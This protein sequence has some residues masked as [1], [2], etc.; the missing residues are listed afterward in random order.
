MM[1]KKKRTALDMART[2]AAPNPPPAKSARAGYQVNLSEGE[3]ALIARG[4]ELSGLELST[5]MRSASIQA[6]RKLASEA[7]SA[8]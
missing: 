1:T 2:T 5:F 3:K 4:A 8:T 7:G 6:A